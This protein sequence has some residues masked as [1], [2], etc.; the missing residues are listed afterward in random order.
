MIYK[1]KLLE[2]K[3][4][5]N[6]LFLFLLLP[7]LNSA[8]A[9]NSVTGTWS[10]LYTS[11]VIPVACANLPD[12]RILAWVGNEYFFRPVHCIAQAM[13]KNIG[14][15]QS[16][17]TSSYA[18]GNNNQRFKIEPISSV[19]NGATIAEGTYYI[20]SKSSGKIIEVADASNLNGANVQQG[21]LSNATNEQFEI[22]AS[23]AG[24]YSIIA[25]HSNKAVEVAGASLAIGANISQ[26][27]I[28]G[29]PAQDWKFIPTGNGYF[30]I[31]SKLS[32]ARLM[33]L[34]DLNPADGTNIKVF[35]PNGSAAQAWK[36]VPVTNSSTTAIIAEGTY[37][38]ESK[39]SGKII[40][41]AGASNVNGANVQQGTLSNATNEQFEINNSVVLPNGE[42][43]AIGGP[44]EL[45]LVLLQ[46]GAL[47]L[48]R[49]LQMGIII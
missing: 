13:D 32:D 41:V 38:I 15:G 48:L 34:D 28:N 25:K 49:S 26:Y 37:Y 19:L 2:N 46:E 20:E 17:I 10:P 39:S 44:L 21:T 5:F 31:V 36:L 18:Q 4:L 9:Q 23:S 45:A 16:V 30:T 35:T 22:K 42:V 6:T 33:D 47:L 14:A 1:Q 27:A 29:T 43:V 12:G 3:N 24:H 40:E 8:A 11:D 7:I